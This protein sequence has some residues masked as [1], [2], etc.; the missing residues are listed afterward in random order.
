MH[1]CTVNV[2]HYTY[3]YREAHFHRCLIDVNVLHC[4]CTVHV[5]HYTYTHG[6]VHVQ[7]C[8]SICSYGT[9][10]RLMS[11]RFPLIALRSLVARK[12]Q[13]LQTH[14]VTLEGECYITVEAH[15][16]QLTV[17][18]LVQVPQCHIQ[19]DVSFCLQSA[20]GLYRLCG[21]HGDVNPH[22]EPLLR[23]TSN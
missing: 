16:V 11:L 13:S 19:P 22:S 17:P 12:I 15:P 9:V 20:C 14:K 10:L 21:I 1:V 7:G 5:L 8:P 23:P 4:T 18:T 3:M 6:L 2:L